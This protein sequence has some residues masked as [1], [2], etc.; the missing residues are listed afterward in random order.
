VQV[1]ERIGTPEAEK[2]LKSLTLGA[3]DR[4]QTKDA[5]AAT[6][7]LEARR[8]LAAVRVLTDSDVEAAR[9]HRVGSREPRRLQGHLTSVTYLLFSADGKI[10]LSSGLDGVVMLHQVD[11]ER[12]IRRFEEAKGV[13]GAA[14]SPDGKRLA[15]AGADGHVRLWDP[16]TGRK[17][18]QLAG[19]KKGALCVAFSTD[20]KTLASGGADGM[21]RLWR[22]GDGKPVAEL[23]ALASK[24][25]ALAFSPDGKSLA[26]AGLS[27][28]SRAFAGGVTFLGPEHVQLWDL[29]AGKDRKLNVQGSQVAFMADGSGLIASGRFTV[30]GRNPGGPAYIGWGKESLYDATRITWWDLLQ[31]RELGL[32]ER[33]GGSAVV[34]GDGTVAASCNGYEGHHGYLSWGSNSLGA[35]PEPGQ[36]VRLWDTLGRQEVLSRKLQDVTAVALSA[37]G[38]RLAWGNEKGR[39]TLWDLAPKDALACYPG[40]PGPKDLE[41]LW[42]DLGGDPARAFQAGWTLAA[43]RRTAWLAER[44]KPVELADGKRTTKLIEDLDSDQFA[45]REAATRELEKLGPGVE[46]ALRRAKESKL[47][48]EAGRR[49]ARLL[50]KLAGRVLPPEELRQVRGVH[51]LERIGSPEAVRVLVRVARGEPTALL[52]REA[53]AALQ[54][55][56]KH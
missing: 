20:S 52:T 7:R 32:A 24:V 47:S 29:R 45:V 35:G 31:G 53:R 11:T 6:Q 27:M 9:R 49:I 2:L 19:H 56:K 5:V 16:L 46:P 34:S 10:L 39:I 48:P 26:A 18:H 4:A 28:Q 42:E 25:T 38:R 15:S 44:V 50:N 8:R 3:P 12:E 1:L 30:I 41:A 17:L 36:A 23:R 13:S 54:R 14:L 22:V 33:Q 40:G 55:L 43:T 21:I 51:V 37:D